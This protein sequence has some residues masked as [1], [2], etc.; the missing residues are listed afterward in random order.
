[1]NWEKFYSVVFLLG[2][3]AEFVLLGVLLVRRRYRS[4]PVFTAYITFNVLSDIALG[5][6]AAQ[7]PKAA[8]SWTALGLLAPQYLLELGVLCEIAWHVLKP[9]SPSLDWL[10]PSACPR[11]DSCARS[12]LAR[13]A[14]LSFGYRLRST[15]RSR[16]L[17]S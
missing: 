13:S 15:S 2:G 7:F 14:V 17:H 12:A 6:L 9:V 8:A 5:I 11:Q 3:L 1:M 4:F 16:R 10:V